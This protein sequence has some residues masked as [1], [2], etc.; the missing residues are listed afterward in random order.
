MPL[1]NKG[2]VGRLAVA[3][4]LLPLL[5]GAAVTRGWAVFVDPASLLFPCLWFILLLENRVSSGR[6]SDGRAFILGS[7]FSFFYEGLWT[8][9]MQDPA[10][11]SGLDWAAVLGGPLEWG[12]LAVLLLHVLR[13]VVPRFPGEPDRRPSW[14][15]PL[16]VS[17][18]A[19]A[20]LVYAW[21]SVFGHYRA[22]HCLGPMWLLDDVALAA[23]GVCLWRGR[24]RDRDAPI[25][26]R[27]LWIWSVAAA[28]L[29]LLGSGLVA[30]FCAAWGMARGPALAAQVF[31]LV[32][33]GVF[34]WAARR[35]PF[36]AAESV[37][38]SRPILVAAA[39]R[40]GGTLL[41]LGLFGS[42]DDPRM[43]F[44]SGLLCDWPSKLL[45]YY[46][47]LTTRVEL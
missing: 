45:F 7:G 24:G 25:A 46:A 30:Q 8:K 41:L 42:H 3:L 10:A 18:G 31:W 17:I 5:S 29:F 11:L 36:G 12:M 21:K 37:A 1:R 15:G 28:G 26:A 9:R 35:E 44:W 6:L 23:A 34:L 27:P 22:E 19:G 43:A 14:T 4:A 2:A 32:V 20:G 16:L 47:F 13:V 39:V 38:C 40:V 33:L